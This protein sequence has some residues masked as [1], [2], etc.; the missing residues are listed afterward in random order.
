MVYNFKYPYKKAK[1]KFVFLL[2]AERFR[3]YP[4]LK[5]IYYE[6]NRKAK[7]HWQ[8]YQP[9]KGVKR[10][11]TGGTGYCTWYQPTGDLDN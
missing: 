6:H 10:N 8:E 1:Q 2:S 7:T 11:E 5:I 3:T 9:V 4:H